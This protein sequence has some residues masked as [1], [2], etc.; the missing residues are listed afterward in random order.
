MNLEFITKEGSR[1]CVSGKREGGMGKKSRG[2][3]SLTVCVKLE[4]APGPVYSHV[5]DLKSK[6]LA[7]SFELCTMKHPQTL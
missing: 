4:R 3:N 7:Y 1:V 5:R 6:R 2:M